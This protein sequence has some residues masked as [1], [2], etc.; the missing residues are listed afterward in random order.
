MS[1]SS[2]EDDLL[3]DLHSIATIKAD[4]K[5]SVSDEY[6]SLQPPTPGLWM[7]RYLR[8]D[9]RR[10]TIEKVKKIVDYCL[11]FSQT[12]IEIM[13]MA[14]LLITPS[15][16]MVEGDV[17]NRCR[18]RFLR[19]EI[20]TTAMQ[21]ALGGL[22]QLELTYTQTISSQI[23]VRVIKLEKQITQNVKHLHH[24]RTIFGPGVRPH[25]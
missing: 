15:S 18:E 20:L 5:L 6:I 21:E 24:F 23:N 12:H 2:P 22:Q 16:K 3:I 4:C 17:T 7:M 8:G 9:N 13:S 19:L 14:H 25:E 1:T 11:E 10:R